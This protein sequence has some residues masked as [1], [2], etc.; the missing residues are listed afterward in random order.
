VPRTPE[1]HGQRSFSQLRDRSSLLSG[2]IT[3]AVRGNP[4][5]ICFPVI[6][7]QLY[8]NLINEL[9]HLQSSVG[10]AEKDGDQMNILHSAYYT[11]SYPDV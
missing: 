7:T 6:S 2:H 10:R 3:S 1:N 11:K 8:H 4:N 9:R 5:K